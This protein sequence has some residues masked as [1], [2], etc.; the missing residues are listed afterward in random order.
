MQKNN[1]SASFYS[2]CLLS[3][4]V[5]QVHIGSNHSE[6]IGEL[7]VEGPMKDTTLSLPFIIGIGAGAGILLSIILVIF[8]A[9]RRKSQESDRVLKR[10]QNQMDILEAKVAKECKEGEVIRGQGHRVMGLSISC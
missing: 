6:Y 5:I 7:Q 2:T 8:I 9:Y 10:M 4:C 1:T 3:S